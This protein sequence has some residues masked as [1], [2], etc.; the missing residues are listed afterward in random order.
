LRYDAFVDARTANHPC[1]ASPVN[2]FFIEIIDNGDVSIGVTCDD[3][4]ND[5]EALNWTYFY[6]GRYRSD[7]ARLYRG[8]DENGNP[9]GLI[10]EVKPPAYL[11]ER[12]RQ[13]E[14]EGLDLPTRARR[15]RH[16]I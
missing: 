10:G 13:F 12:D 11:A 1:G 16:R 2:A 8:L 3:C 9:V 4:R 7:A 5:I 15:E 14:K 6:L